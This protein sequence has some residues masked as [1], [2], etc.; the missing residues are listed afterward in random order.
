M[1]HTGIPRS[2]AA[3]MSMARLRMPVVT[4]SLR[5]GSLPMSEAGKGV[6]SRMATTTSK[7]RIAAATASSP[8]MYSLNTVS[9]TSFGRLFQSAVSSATFW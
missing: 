2:R 9:S 5:F 6:R 8:L 7:S 1:P 3:S 4:S